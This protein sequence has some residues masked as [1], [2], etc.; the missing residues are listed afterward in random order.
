MEITPYLF[1]NG[2]CEAAMTRYAEV[3]RVPAPEFVRVSDMPPEDQAAMAGAPAAAVMNCALVLGG[4]MI[5]ASD[6]VSGDS[7]GMAGASIHIGLPSVAEAHR[8]FAELAEGGRVGMA[9]GETFWTPAFGT[10]TD[11]FGMRWMVS[12]AEGAAV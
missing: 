7:P 8:V 4:A 1:F 10:L 3:F 5:M 2:T 11:R 6:D 12:V 9:M